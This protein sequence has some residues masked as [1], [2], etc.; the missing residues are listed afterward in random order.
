MLKSKEYFFF[1]IFF[2]LYLFFI[3]SQNTILFTNDSINFIR[4][5]IIIKSYIYDLQLEISEKFFYPLFY[6]FI[7]SNFISTTDVVELYNCYNNVNLCKIYFQKVIIFQSIILFLTGI[8]AFL[9]ADTL[10]KK[11]SISYAVFFIFFLNSYYYSRIFFVTPEVLSIFFLTLNFFFIIL[12]LDKKKLIFFLLLIFTSSILVLFKPIF[13]IINFF[14]FLYILI[15]RKINI[16]HFILFLTLLISIFVISTNYKKILF[17]ENDFKYEMTVIEQRT[18]YGTI[19]YSEIIPLFFSFIPKIGDNINKIV[20]DKK[21]IEKVELQENKRN[22]FYNNRDKILKKNNSA[23]SLKKIFYKNLQ[24][25]DKQIIL[26]PIFLFRGIFM[27]SG[28][29][30]YFVNFDGIFT[31]LYIYFNYIITYISPQNFRKISW[32]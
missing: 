5:A 21:T 8:L 14:F 13:L 24:N 32:N 7:L 12:F 27:Q 3:S 25:F 18:A 11:K 23:L 6:S 1:I 20:F 31:K 19:N 29:S 22:F 10:L 15:I 16:K 9:I 28:F 26:T 2:L 4:N 17:Y 30:D